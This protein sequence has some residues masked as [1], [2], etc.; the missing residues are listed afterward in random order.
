MRRYYRNG[1]RN[2]GLADEPD[3]TPFKPVRAIRRTCNHDATCNGA[4]AI[5]SLFVSQ[6]RPR[7]RPSELAIIG[8]RVR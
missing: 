6:W 1:A 3:Q 8:Q 5:K 2:L 4:M 7:R